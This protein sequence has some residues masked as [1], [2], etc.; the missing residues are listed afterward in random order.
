MYFH[1]VDRSV[2]KDAISLKTF[3]VYILYAYTCIFYKFK[4]TQI[5]YLRYFTMFRKG[6][7]WSNIH[8]LWFSHFLFQ[9]AC[10]LQVAV[11]NYAQM[12]NFFWML[13]EGLYLHIIIVWTYSADKIKR[14]YLIV[15][16]WGK[17][18]GDCYSLDLFLSRKL[19]TYILFSSLGKN[20]RRFFLV[21][22][23]EA[24]TKTSTSLF[25]FIYFVLFCWGGGR[26]E[27]I[28]FAL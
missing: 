11:F 22:C 10:K 9:W 28:S 2:K 15:L 13:V 21:P 16:G 5:N 24:W 18:E 6:R 8:S 26:F 1:N 12:T 25:L 14:W 19:E 27:E 17:F 20:E 23:L 7:I 3:F 4:D